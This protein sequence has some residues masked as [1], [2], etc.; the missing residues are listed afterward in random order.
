MDLSSARARIKLMKRKQHDSLDALRI[1]NKPKKTRTAWLQLNIKILDA[2]YGKFNLIIEYK[3]YRSTKDRVNTRIYF[4]IDNNNLAGLVRVVLD[5]KKM[6][7]E[8]H[9]LP[10]YISN[11]ALER[12]LCSEYAIGSHDFISAF[13]QLLQAL[14]KS[15]WGYKEGLNL[16]TPA[17][18]LCA[19]RD[20]DLNSNGDTVDFF[21]IKT[22]IKHESFTLGNEH[23]R[24]YQDVTKTGEMKKVFVRKPNA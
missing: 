14:T 19:I 5:T 22:F 24:H 12:M 8:Q 7:T 2:I 15:S 6:T 3:E 10:G 11:H 17:G 23:D 9:E 13:N 20:R 16:Y 4:S 21:M 18:V 1:A